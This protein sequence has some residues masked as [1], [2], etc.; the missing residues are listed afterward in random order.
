MYHRIMHLVHTPRYSGAEILVRDLCLLHQSRGIDTA[1]ASFAPATPDFLPILEHLRRAGTQIYIPSREAVGWQRVKDF[2]YAYRDFR[3]EVAYGHSVLPALYGRLALPWIGHK[4]RFVAVLHNANNDDYADPKL[5]LSELVLAKRASHIFAVSKEGAESYKLRISHHPPI[6]VVPNGTNVS[7]IREALEK[8]Q[9]WRERYGLTSEKR[10]ILQVGRLSPTKQQHLT[11]HALARILKES[12][13]IRL[14]FAGLTQNAE[15]EE[16]LRTDIGR[17]CVGN[18]IEILGGRNDVPGLL[19]AADLYVMPSLIEAHS[20]AMIE[21]LASG[22][23]IVASDIPAF[24]FSATYLGVCLIA[25][26]DPANFTAAAV[27]LLQAGG[28]YDR[29]VEYF[30]IERVA[31]VYGGYS[32]NNQPSS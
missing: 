8:R 22:V 31:G 12:P 10:L 21:A 24:R 27:K 4:P 13:H 11:L 18:Q 29:N 19:A 25:P 6:E 3:P 30:D 15:Y 2:S 7:K 14:W 17:L 9:Y 16:R 1:I 5:R 28:R 23:P 32:N 20:I 26:D